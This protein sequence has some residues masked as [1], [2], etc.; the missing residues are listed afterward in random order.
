M[1]CKEVIKKLKSLRNKR[2]IEGMRRFGI[3]TKNT[4]G[5]SV[6]VL[7]EIA[8]KLGKDQKLAE[9]LW[10]S[11]IHEARI[12]ASMVAENVTEKL[13]DKWVKE[14]DSWDVCDQFCMNLFDK[15]P[16][17]IKKVKQWSKRKEEFVKRAGFAMMAAMA[18]HRKDLKD[19]V[20]IS[21]LPIIKRESKDDRNFV[22]KAVNWAL[23]GIGK[24]N[25]RL[26][27]YALN[28]A[29][30]ISKINSKSAKWIAVDAIRELNDRSKKFN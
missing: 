2:N 12:L 28:T 23:R 1:E 11:R 19:S 8:K 22:K 10:N 18:S 26:N 21:F 30:E 9:C 16:F 15:L 17:S 27:K 14:F 3:N 4:L 6:F 24:R 13:A 7:R 25:K 29:K 5:V 20:F